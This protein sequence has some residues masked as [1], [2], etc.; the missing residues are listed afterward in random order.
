M[1]AASRTGRI[2]NTEWPTIVARRQNGET[3]AAIARDYEVTGPAI[4]YIVDKAQAEGVAAAP[5]PAMAPTEA[6]A[7]A[8]ER[9]RT[10]TITIAN[11]ALGRERDVEA[12]PDEPRRDE[13]PREEPARQE[14][15]AAAP[16]TPAASMDTPLA[17]RLM[18]AAG[19]CAALIQQAEH[20]GSTLD[21]TIK[22]ALHQVRRAVAA[23]EIE[24]NRSASSA[25]PA[26]PSR[27]P[28]RAPMREPQ[29]TRPAQAA[30][31]PPVSDLPIDDGNGFG[32]QMVQG[33]VKFFHADKGFGFVIP[34]D[35]GSDIYVPL[36]AL[37]GSGLNTLESEQRVRVSVTRGA[38]GPEAKEVEPLA[39]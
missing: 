7:P 28:T 22:N 4:K 29:A 16:A 5:E 6:E 17:R 25:R 20:A 32:S 36:K 18:D 34:D 2:P 10:K 9:P 21:E 12:A 39:A 14:P 35:G 24:M 30:P 23:I 15:A 11:T 13:A 19:E 3:Y 38:K 27:Q 1:P 31:R 8:A 26:I 33:T 37:R